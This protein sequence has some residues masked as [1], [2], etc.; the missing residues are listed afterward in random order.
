MN[1]ITAFLNE[2]IGDHIVYVKQPLGYEIRVNLVC[3]LQKALYGLKQSPRIWYQLL[4]NFLILQGFVC[5]EADHS[6]FVSL[7]RGLILG[8]YVDD[9]L[10]IES[11]QKECDEIK[12]ALT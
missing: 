10:V 7:A 8:V 6:I 11:T 5:T 3:Q 2:A 4:P 12:R 9:M 1:F